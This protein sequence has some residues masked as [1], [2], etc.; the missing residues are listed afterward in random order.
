M[1]RGSMQE[2]SYIWYIGDLYL[3]LPNDN[4]IDYTN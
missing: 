1:K 2:T 4:S 3:I